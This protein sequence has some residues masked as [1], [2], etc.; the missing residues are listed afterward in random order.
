V[1]VELTG[2]PTGLVLT[3][4]DDGRGF[5]FA[6]RLEDDRLWAEHTGPRVIKERARA[7]GASLSIESRPG[8]GARLDLVI[9]DAA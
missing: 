4:A 5:R 3:I 2:A 7:I 9:P 6:G 8:L 1:T